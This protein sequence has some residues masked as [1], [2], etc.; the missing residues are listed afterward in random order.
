MLNIAIRAA[1]KAGNVVIKAYENPVSI[2]A[3]LKKENDFVTNIDKSA[4]AAIIEVIKAAYPDHT[5]IAEESGLIKNKDEESQW[6]IDPIDGTTNFIRGFPHFAIS[7][8]YRH[9]GKTELGVVF[10]PITNELYSAERGKGA[11]LNGFRLRVN[12]HLRDLTG[13]LIGMAYPL[14]VKEHT[15]SYAKTL[16][17]LFVKASDFR[18]S[19]SAALD[20]CYVASGRLDLFF[21]IG[22]KPWDIT[23]GEVIVRE[24]GGILTDFVGG[25]NYLVSGNI[26]AGSP[27]IVKDFIAI[28]QTTLSESLKC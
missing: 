23:A 19:G 17:A 3:E 9:K 10:N 6:I 4:E 18:C 21:E 27:K 20:L 25:T 16:D 24:S 13:A 26:V 8:A 2:R 1:R 12:S 7:I 5:V 22:L 28:S 15:E 11:Q 14:H